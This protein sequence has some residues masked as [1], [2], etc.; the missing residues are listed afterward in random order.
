M[1]QA[2]KLCYY[3]DK[4]EILAKK[5]AIDY[6]KPVHKLQYSFEDLF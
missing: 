2:D 4:A 5:M 1:Q 3:E 6:S